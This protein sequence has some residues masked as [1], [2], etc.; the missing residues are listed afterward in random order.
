MGLF[1]LPWLLLSASTKN[2]FL[3]VTIS[4]YVFPFTEQ[5]GQVVVQGRLSLYAFL[6]FSP[7]GQMIRNE[8]RWDEMN[9]TL[10]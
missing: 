1:I 7:S 8:M 5:S 6:W 3:T 4:I 10:L 2:F 9:M